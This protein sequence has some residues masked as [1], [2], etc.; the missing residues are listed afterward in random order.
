MSV[1]FEDFLTS[2]KE[3]LDNPNSAE[4]D[5]RNLISRSYYSLFHLS[6][7]QAIT[8]NLPIPNISSKEYSELGSHEKIFIKFEKHS[9]TKIKA[10]GRMMYQRKDWRRK[11][12]YEL[13][14]SITK[15]QAQQ[16]FFAVVG[17]LEKL[18]QLK[19]SE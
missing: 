17:L 18:K 13:S 15:Y 3:L 12:D 5:F 4:I 1:S 2:A 14:E 6:K 7:Q 19:I 8:L 10:L 11:A 16:H 9:D